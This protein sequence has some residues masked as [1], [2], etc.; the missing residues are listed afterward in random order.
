MPDLKPLKYVIFDWDNTLVESR[1]CLVAV[2]NQVL[3]EYKMPNWDI[4]KN[5]RDPDL[6]FGDNFPQIFGPQLAEEA[7]ERYAQIYATQAPSMVTTFPG[8]ISVLE[9]FRRRNIPL[10]IVSNKDRRLLEME[11]PLLFKPEWFS[12][13]ICGHEAPRDKPYPDQLLY[14]L[15]GWLKPQQITPQNVWMVGDSRQDNLCA[16]AAHAQA[17]RIGQ[18]IWEE[19]DCSDER[20]VFFKDF[21]SFAEFLKKADQP[22]C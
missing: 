21:I 6:S 12:R 7:Y 8:V 16:L 11:L 14:A 22:S 9:F 15:D 1:T 5:R 17:I 10:L 4:V 2:V 13:I 19:E 18:P 20:I 3:A